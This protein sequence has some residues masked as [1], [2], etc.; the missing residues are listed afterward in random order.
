MLF[1]DMN[2]TVMPINTIDGCSHTIKAGYFKMGTTN[3]L[4]RIIL[5]KQDGYIATGVIEIWDEKRA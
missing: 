2:K 4:R 5:G 1:Q 3:F